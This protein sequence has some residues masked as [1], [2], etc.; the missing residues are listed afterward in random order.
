MLR[1]Y[2][3]SCMLCPKQDPKSGPGRAVILSVSNRQ[4]HMHVTAQVSIMAQGHAMMRLGTT[5]LPG[6]R[7]YSMQHK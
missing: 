2:V 5:L 4:Q 1:L 3:N 7:C 6:L